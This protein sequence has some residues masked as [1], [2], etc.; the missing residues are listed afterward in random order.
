MA[1][2]L[3]HFLSHIKRANAAKVRKYM[4]QGL[5]R[6]DAYRKAYPSGQSNLPRQG[7]KSASSVLQQ[8]QLG[9]SSED[10]GDKVAVVDD[11]LHESEEDAAKRRLGE[12]LRRR[13][14][15]GSDT[16][17]ESPNPPRDNS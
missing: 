16:G 17:S 2:G 6:E 9:F 7:Y 8:T 13:Q 1:L 11:N 14:R 12:M 3:G 10:L 15:S 4:S 5:S